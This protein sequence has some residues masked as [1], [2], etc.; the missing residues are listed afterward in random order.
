MKKQGFPDYIVNTSPIQYLHQAGLL[1]ILAAMLG[2]VIVPTAVAD[3][4]A[5]GRDL[6]LD[7]PDPA[8]LAWMEIKRPVSAPVLPL[9]VDLGSGETEVL[10][11][12][13][14]IAGSVVVIDDAVARRVA[15]T[16][17]IP[18][19]GTL[20]LL[21]DAKRKGVVLEIKPVLDNLDEL[22]FRC[23]EQ[24]RASILRLA[25]EE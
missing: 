16:V 20:G 23:S 6:K 8:N 22:R 17:G 9:V 13:K 1:H 10:A 14:E 4:L 21:P 11:L 25:G 15:K 12:A 5:A 19:T 3:E 18:L 7:L 24:T 2:R